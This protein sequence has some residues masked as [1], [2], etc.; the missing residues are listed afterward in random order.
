MKNKP[1]FAVLAFLL[2]A[3]A[4][5]AKA[6]SEPVSIVAE[7]QLAQLKSN[8]GIF[9]KNVE[10]VHGKRKIKADRLEVHRREDLGENAELLVA[11]GNPAIFQETQ[12]DGS[13][14]KASAKEV[15]YDVT[16]RLLTIKGDAEISQA[17][18]KINAEVIVYDM[19]KQLISA[20]RG[21]ASQSRVR[22]ILVPEQKKPAK[23]QGKS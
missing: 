11:T 5:A 23:E 20:E 15:R 21:E 19:E 16:N 10:I 6:P 1:V 9:E 4:F 7:K 22:T 17:G 2:S 14:L 12:I 8:I 13:I 3:P 18:Q